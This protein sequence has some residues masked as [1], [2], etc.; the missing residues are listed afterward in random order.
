M[1]LGDWGLFQVWW[2]RRARPEPEEKHLRPLGERDLAEPR[3]ILG[4]RHWFPLSLGVL[5]R[6]ILKDFL[7]PDPPRSILFSKDID[8]MA[9]ALSNKR[10]V[11]VDMIALAPVEPSTA[12]K[13]PK[14]LSL[15]QLSLV[16][17]EVYHLAGEAKSYQNRLV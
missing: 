15:R 9:K 2:R 13:L 1:N 6:H 8:G 7:E 10:L 5:S 4:D 17:A 12:L 16:V 11:E 3:V 14:P